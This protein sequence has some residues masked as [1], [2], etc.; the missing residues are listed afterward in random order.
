[1]HDF[2]KVCR[3][4]DIPEN[5]SKVV[6][7]GIDSIALFRV[8]EDIFAV[9]DVCPHAGGPLSKGTLSGTMLTCPWHNMTFDLTNGSCPQAPF[10][11]V[12][13]F[14]VSVDGEDVLVRLFDEED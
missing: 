8:G 10:L 5:G 13:T 11:S 6:T 2:E 12:R 4:N 3:L 9:S 7:L 14:A 1:M